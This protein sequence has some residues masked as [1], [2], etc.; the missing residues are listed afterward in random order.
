VVKIAT[1]A[2]PENVSTKPMTDKKEIPQHEAMDTILRYLIDNKSDRPIHSHTIWKEVYPDQEE[3]IVYFLLRK[4]MTTADD[5]VITHIRSIETHN[6]EVFFEANAITKRYLEEQ[7]GFTKQY[8]REQADKIE[9]IRIDTLQT[10]K[11]ESEVDIIRFQRGLGKRLTIWG[12]I[13]TAISILVSFLTS[14]YQTQPTRNLEN[15]VSLLK[16]KLDSVTYSLQQTTLQLQNIELQL[17]KDT[18]SSN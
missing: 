16:K 2:K 13:L 14:L 4:I 1:F 3:E 12:V 10:E 5:I 15:E 6:F 11:L 17:S 7:G 18:L 8:L 9:Q